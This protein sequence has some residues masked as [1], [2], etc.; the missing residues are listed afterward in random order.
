[1]RT[2][3]ALSAVALLACGGAAFAGPAS[4][5]WNDPHVRIPG[6]FNPATG[7]FRPIERPAG[8]VI[9]GSLHQAEVRIRI[10]YTFKRPIIALCH[11]TK[12]VF[13]VGT[14]A[15]VDSLVLQ[16]WK[17]G[18]DLYFSFRSDDPRTEVGGNVQYALDSSGETPD[19]VQVS[20]SCASVY[21]DTS[22]TGADAAPPQAIIPAA[23]GGTAI[24]NVSL[25]V[26]MS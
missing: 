7:V 4:P 12:R 22:S 5:P 14:G 15:D 1:M 21:S 20:I 19:R 10:K 26:T 6:Y 25:Q 18:P 8:S 23:G 11:I 24:V 9:F 16:P 2:H 3:I 13:T 17:G